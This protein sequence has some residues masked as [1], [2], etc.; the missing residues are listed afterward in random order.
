MQTAHLAAL[1]AQRLV[2]IVRGR[3]VRVHAYTLLLVYL[4]IL[5][6][7]ITK[8]LDTKQTYLLCFVCS[9]VSVKFFFSNLRVVVDPPLVWSDDVGVPPV[10]RRPV[11][12]VG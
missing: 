4:F 2:V 1:V 8:M 3:L 11:E 9:V 10:G 5:E 12:Y 6:N 7:I